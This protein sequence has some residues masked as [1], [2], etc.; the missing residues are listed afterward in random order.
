M[1]RL[2]TS[3]IMGYPNLRLSAKEIGS[4]L[5][6]ESEDL[7]KRVTEVTT[8]NFTYN[9]EYRVDITDNKKEELFESWLYKQ[10]YGVKTYMFGAPYSFCRNKESFIDLIKTFLENKN[11]IAAYEKE[12]EIWK[13]V[14]SNVV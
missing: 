13:Q 10:N 11:Y 4:A 12:L 14:G 7:M 8:E 9:D 1:Q 3:P 5:R 2:S 6:A